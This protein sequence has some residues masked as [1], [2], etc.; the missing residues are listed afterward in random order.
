MSSQF[1]KRLALAVGI[2]FAGCIGLAHAQGTMPETGTNNIS[3]G[4]PSPYATTNVSAPSSTANEASRSG[5]R[6]VER[7]RDV[8]E[9]SGGGIVNGETAGRAAAREA[10]R[11]NVRNGMNNQ[12]NNTSGGYQQAVSP[13][14]DN[15]TMNPGQAPAAPQPASVAPNF[16]AGNAPMANQ[17]SGQMPGNIGAG[18]MSPLKK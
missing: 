6:A 2:T 7:N 9:T 16:G 5:A 17:P 1:P 12:V 8:V 13:T 10:A 14:P 4:N 15:R 18:G 3:A 11:N